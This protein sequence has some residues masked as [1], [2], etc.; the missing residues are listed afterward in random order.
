MSLYRRHIS[1]NGKSKSNINQNQNK[2]K[3]TPSINSI[4]D[5]GTTSLFESMRTGYYRKTN[6]DEISLEK[7]LEKAASVR[8]KTPP[9]FSMTQ[10]VNWIHRVYALEV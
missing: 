4:P 10:T 1:D 3:A 9:A 8:S 7:L 2:Q 5:R 6:S